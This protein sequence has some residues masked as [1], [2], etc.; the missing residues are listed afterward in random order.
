MDGLSGAFAAQRLQLAAK[1]ALAA[2]LAFLI[3][4]LMPGSASHYAYYAPLGALVAMYHNV[5][6]SVRQGV[7]ALT[8]LAV[9]IGLAVVLV[10]IADPSPLTVAIFMGI[11]VLLGG[12]PGLGSG[13]DWIPT[14]ALLVLLV[15]G[16]NAD[17]FSFGYLVQMGAGVAVGIAV[18]FL[19]FPPLH[20]KAAAASLDDLRLALGRQ[21][22]DMGTALKEEWPPEHEE[23]SRRSDELASATRSVRHLVK[24]ADASR[25]AN[26]RRKL[27]PRD[28]DRDYRN[29]RQLE[30]VSFHVQDMT[31]VLSDV[32]WESDV[33]YTVPLEDNTPLANAIIA[34]GELLC[35]F[36]NED[37][38]RQAERFTAA[39][40]AVEACMATTAARELDQGA[41]PAS[42]S[43]LLSLHRILR[44]VPPGTEAPA[45]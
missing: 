38:D 26:P 15:G 35:S 37:E 23:W 29:L 43:I 7:Q 22:T 12:L 32:I 44:S 11:G 41:V 20:L 24:E 39:K 45:S 40:S 27:H 5:A 4:P 18:N 14:A 31:D 42:E 28:I 34:T 10:N 8:G 16:S 25:R 17:D 2:G 36:S 33:P 3:A 21:M 13:S 19:V 6:G 30:R 1:A 9:G